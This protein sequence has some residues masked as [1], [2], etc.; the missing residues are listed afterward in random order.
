MTFVKMPSKPM[1]AKKLRKVMGAEG[2][3]MAPGMIETRDKYSG[4]RAGRSQKA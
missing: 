4:L 3:W 1:P 2:F